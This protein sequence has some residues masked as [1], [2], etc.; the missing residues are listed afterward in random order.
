MWDWGTEPRPPQNK[1]C[2]ELP[3]LPLSVLPNQPSLGTWGMDGGTLPIIAWGLVGFQAK[4]TLVNTWF[5]LTIQ[6]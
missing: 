5:R 2:I 6:F 1:T 3:V 4:A